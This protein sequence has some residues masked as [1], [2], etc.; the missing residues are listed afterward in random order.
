MVLGGTKDQV[1]LIT[2]TNNINFNALSS[3]LSI[4]SDSG[5]SRPSL[6]S[7]GTKII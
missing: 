7:L 5:I 1:D 3:Q 4:H 2:S 6:S